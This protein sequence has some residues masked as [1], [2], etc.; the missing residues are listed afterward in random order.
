MAKLAAK[1]R[2]KVSKADAVTG[3]F[4]PLSPGKYVATLK[5]VE[6][7]MSAAGNPMWVA[8]FE[9]LHNLDG[10]RQPGRQWYNLNLPTSDTPPDGYAKGAE[11]WE[12]YQAL[13]AGRIKS[14]FE[15]FG[16]ELDSDTDE[17]IGEQ[18][19]LT[20]GI[21]TIQNGDRKGQKTNS[22]NAVSSVDSVQ[23]ADAIGG[24]DDDDDEF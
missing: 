8:E 22:V 7:K 13:C 3:D 10:D 17:M 4:E 24:A 18:A 20:I 9:D 5:G 19:V 23:G 21:R 2:K 15:A 14:F 11:K 16:Y 1:D 12:Q 6:A